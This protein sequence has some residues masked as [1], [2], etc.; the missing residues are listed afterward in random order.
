MKNFSRKRKT[1]RFEP[2]EDRTLLSLTAVADFEGLFNINNPQNYWNGDYSDEKVGTPNSFISGPCEFD[3]LALTD[4]YYSWWNGF[5]YSQTTDTQTP[6]YTNQMSAITG[7]GANVTPTYGIGYYDFYSEATPQ[8]SITDDYI[9]NYEFSSL[10]ITNTTYAALSILN[11][12]EFADSFSDGDHFELIITGYDAENHSVGNVEVILADYRDGK[13]F[14]LDVW[15]EV[16][17]SSLK[18]AV[19]LEFTLETTDNNDY[20][21]TTPFY[22]AVDEITLTNKSYIVTDFEDVGANLDPESV[23]STDGNISASPGDHDFHSGICTFSSGGD[24]NEYQYWYGWEYSNKTDT[25]TPG[26]SND[27]SAYTGTGANGSSTYGVAYAM[28][29]PGWAD[30]LPLITLNDSDNYDFDSIQITNTTYAALSMLNGDSIGKK[31]GGETGDDPDWFKLTIT[32]FNEWDWN[33]DDWGSPIR[34]PNGS[35]GEVEFYLA[36]Y[37]FEDNYQD[38]IVDTWTTVDISPLKGYKNLEFNFS[39]SDSDPAYGMNTPAYCAIDNLVVKKKDYIAQPTSLVVTTAADVV[40]PYDGVTSLREAITAINDQETDLTTI[41][42]ADNVTRV[43]L[44]SELTITTAITIEGNG[45][46][47]D[48]NSKS[49]IFTIDAGFEDAVVINGLTFA[50]GYMLAHGGYGGAIYQIGGNVTLTGVTFEN[51][52]AKLGGAYF[53]KAG[54]SE[55]VNATFTGNRSNY[56]GAIY[57]YSGTSTF[58]DNESGQTTFA[59]NTAKWGGAIYLH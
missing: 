40:D 55:F 20:G 25:V 19:S 24:F 29:F 56:G 5:G 17:I 44:I 57:L 35:V 28:S 53:Q 59:N 6:D 21:P 41:T 48:P 8:L 54:T 51:N 16:D 10:M 46:V 33:E 27:G 45:V 52:S 1:L 30:P 36:D 31:F 42:F 15:E 13:T 18:N 14:I 47:L 38:Y 39:S 23:G 9:A 11:G 4:G 34:V 32:G 37:R 7:I 49:R 58:R 12:D 26:Y 43:K 2:L 3:N 22:F 50:N